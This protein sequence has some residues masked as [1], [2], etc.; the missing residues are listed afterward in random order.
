MNKDEKLIEQIVISN[1]A[2]LK[3]LSAM[4]QQAVEFAKYLKTAPS[5]KEVKAVNA[6]GIH[7]HVFTIEEHY[8]LF[9]QQN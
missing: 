6:G 1:E 9:N 5:L 8:Q 7:Y 2:E 3:V 4:E